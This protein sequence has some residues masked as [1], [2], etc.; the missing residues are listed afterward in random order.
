LRA[1]ADRYTE[2]LQVVAEEHRQR[3]R[4]G[5]TAQ[6]ADHDDTAAD[7]RGE[8][9]LL[10]CVLAA[11][12]DDNVDAASVGATSRLSGPVRVLHVIDAVV[13]AERFCAI[14]LL[15]ARR[16]DDYMRAECFRKLQRKDRY[17]AGA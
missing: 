8:H 10:Q 9:G 13:R 2:Q 7:T 5:E 11:D 16:C 12:L 6:N 1:T 17:A 4:T 15:V 3:D 14:E